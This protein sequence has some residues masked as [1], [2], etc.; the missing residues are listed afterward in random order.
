MSKTVLI[1]G[2]SGKIGS[3]S[4]E[5]FARAGWV[6]KKFN[7]TTGN[8][9]RDAEG[10]DV[11]V[12][13]FN[14]PA[15]HDWARIVPALTRDITQAA[16]AAGATVIIPGNVY[17]LDDKGGTWSES[18]RH[19]PPT[20]KGRIREDME[21]AYEASGVQT[22]VLRAGNFIDPRR[23]DDV[24]SLL[25]LRSIKKGKITVAGNPQAL[26]AY[27][28]V[29]DW[30][31]AAVALAERRTSL[32]P[33]EDIPFHGHSFTAVEL[34]Q[35]LEKETGRALD[36]TPFPWPLFSVLAPFWELAREMKEMRYL[37]SLSHSLS[38]A[39]LQRLVPDF[40]GTPLDEV[41]REAIPDELRGRGRTHGQP[42]KKGASLSAP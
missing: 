5:A 9:A 4:A 39:K 33:F 17:N 22:L 41:L 23:Q 34:R 19:A 42:T 1:L 16:R 30:A 31:K 20:R 6:V 18:T 12:N 2:A 38:A 36:F 11:I 26:Q 15:Y 14:P 3:H 35:F 32:R 29:P 28:Y 10:V 24:M 21:R 25:Y 40:E 27:C 13:G 37:Y 7:R 8:L